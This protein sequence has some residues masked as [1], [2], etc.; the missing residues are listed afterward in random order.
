MSNRFAR[1]RFGVLIVVVLLLC[2][3]NAPE[4]DLP[5][6]PG[7]SQTPVSTAISPTN[8]PPPPKTLIV[9]LNREPASLYRYSEAYLYGGT[10]REVDTVLEAIYDGPFDVRGYVHQPVI[11]EKTPSL[12]DGDARIEQ[13]SVTEG[14]VY[15]NPES[16]QPENLELGSPYLPSGCD[17]GSCI[18]TYGGGSV[19]MDR[20]VVDFRLRPGIL[21]SDGEPLTAEDSTFSFQLD[22]SVDTPTTK[23]LVDRTFAYEALDELTTRWTGIP[24]F[25][26][27]EF[28]GNFWSPLPLHLLGGFTPGELL[29]RDEVNRRPVGWGPYLIEDWRPGEQILLRSNPRY[30]RAAEGLPAFEVL[31]FRFLGDESDFALEQLLT[32]EC[33]VVDETLLSLN[34]LSGLAQL[35]GS[36]DVRA[37][38]A[39]GTELARLDFNLAPIPPAEAP[40]L[41]ADLRTRRAIATCIDRGRILEEVVFGWSEIPATYLPTAHPLYAREVEGV[42]YDP[43]RA[44]ALLEEVGWVDEDGNQETP[45]V[46]RG[47]PGVPDGIPLA[48]TLTTAADSGFEPIAD[49]LHDDLLGC[50]VEVTVAFEDSAALFAPWPEGPVFGRTFQAVAWSWPSWVSPL[51]EVFSSAQIPSDDNPIGVNAS[52]FEDEEY[53]ETCQRVLLGP[54]ESQAYREA[55]RR[56]QEIFTEQLPAIPLF[57]KPRLLAY[58]VGICGVDVDPS[59]SSALWNLEVYDAGEAC[60]VGGAPSAVAR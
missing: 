8:E 47:V 51:C 1:A 17:R 22:L 4:V 15:L 58:A 32:G 34:A 46:A 20:M 41:F 11:L 52:G 16:L 29:E 23:Y 21:W 24:G 27:T 43:E 56:T 18:E 2:A 60:G 33:D 37:S 49:R 59:A 25:L 45:R 19:L 3:C 36:G 14:E 57:L 28:Y 31:I 5:I 30:F 53:D 38:W 44:V 12:A 55:V 7:A 9:C 6:T 13:V 50:G 35:A 42:G 39:P 48:F 40:G 26:D 54:P 10:S